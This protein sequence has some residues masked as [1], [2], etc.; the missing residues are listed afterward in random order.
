MDIVT[1]E[2]CT[3]PTIAKLHLDHDQFINKNFKIK[4]HYRLISS[5]FW[6]IQKTYYT[7][8]YSTLPVN[9][10][11]MKGN[12]CWIPFSSCNKAMSNVR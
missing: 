10:R 12:F 6:V 5:F 11:V 3:I 8:E 2:H 4:N 1:N 9:R 7:V